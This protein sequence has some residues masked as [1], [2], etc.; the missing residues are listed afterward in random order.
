MKKIVSAIVTIAFGTVLCIGAGNAP[1]NEIDISSV[2][3]SLAA[4]ASLVIADA[5]QSFN[6]ELTALT[7]NDN[8]SFVVGDGEM[9]AIYEK[10]R[11][12]PEPIP[13]PEP[14]PEPE[15]IFEETSDYEP[16]VSESS[17]ITELKMLIQAEGY[18]MGVEGMEHLTSVFINRMNNNGSSIRGEIYSGA[19]SVVSSGMMWN[20][21][22]I[23][24]ETDYAVDTILNNGPINDALY[25]RTNYYHGFGTPL[26]HYGNVYFSK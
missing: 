4:G 26:F 11:P 5:S 17:A 12:E 14:E 19:Y 20:Q 9:Q 24:P 3:P 1:R 16:P 10:Y 15:M 18:T 7:L 22:Y 23:Y 6:A 25:F 21:Y 8:G 13:E 2:E